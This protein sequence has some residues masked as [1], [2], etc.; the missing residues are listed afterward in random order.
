MGVSDQYHVPAALLPGTNHSTHWIGGWE[1]TTAG[2]GD[3]ENR[4]LSS[5]SGIQTLDHLYHYNILKELFKTTGLVFK[6]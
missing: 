6:V 3:L 4:K 1:G 5:P 2:L